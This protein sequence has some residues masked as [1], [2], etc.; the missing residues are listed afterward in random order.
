MTPTEELSIDD[1]KQKTNAKA[2]IAFGDSTI[3]PEDL[4]ERTNE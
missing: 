1:E 2:P 3:E 4:E